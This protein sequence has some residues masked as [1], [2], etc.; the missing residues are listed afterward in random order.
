VSAAGIEKRWG[1]LHIA[2]EVRYTRW[3]RPAVG[4]FGSRGFTIQSTQ[5]QVDLMV[6]IRFP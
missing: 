2:P 6:G 4:V 1:P 3:N 5:N